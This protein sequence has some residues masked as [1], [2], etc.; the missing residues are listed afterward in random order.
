[1]GEGLREN[2]RE[3]FGLK[4]RMEEDRISMKMEKLVVNGCRQKG[5]SRRR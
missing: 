5:R 4:K 2:K 3:G 1:M